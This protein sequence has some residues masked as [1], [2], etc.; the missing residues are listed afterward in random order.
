MT[1]I[2][3]PAETFPG[4]RR[5]AIVP[6]SV[7]VLDRAGFRVLIETSAGVEAG[8]PDEAYQAQ[9]A[10]VAEERAAVLAADVLLHV[11]CAG[12]NPVAGR[13]DLARLRPGQ[14]VIG[15]CDPLWAPE[16]IRDFAATGATLLSLDLM[17][18][19]TRAQSMDVLSSMAT[20]AGYKAVLLAANELSKMF[21][22]LIT[23]AGTITPARVLVIGAG[24]AGLQAIATARRL[25]GVVEAYDV[26]P[27]VKEEVESLGATFLELPL[28]TA[29]SQDK[30][31]YAR[32]F[33][34]SFYRRQ[35][36][37]LARAV[38]TSDVVIT[39]AVVPGAPAPRLITAEMVR[40]MRPGSVIVDLAA[41]RG[42]NCELTR[43]GASHVIG[44]VR[45]LG[46]V[47]L[48]SELPHDASLMFS[49]NITALVRHLARDG[50]IV[51][52]E[53]DPIA[54]ATLVARDGEVVEPRV[55]ER[56]GSEMEADASVLRARN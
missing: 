33:D 15:L 55:R 4:E 8:H 45:L 27:A 47:N 7:R 40:G 44:G 36:E 48:P 21:P 1:T 6:A 50:A 30:Q 41:E 12:A 14:I 2:G 10:Q 20:L 38:A 37:L 43:P 24:V 3:I 13:E 53:S 25:G 51:L 19:T 9:G 29:D 46:P 31:G 52:E 16:E 22:L 49:K 23:A 54:Q 17:P 26:R 39:T 28:E 18:R 5:V 42:G 34:E 11:R 35:R 56:L 32:S